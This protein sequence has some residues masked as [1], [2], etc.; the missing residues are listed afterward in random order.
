MTQITLKGKPIHTTGTLPAVGTQA[1]DFTLTKTD[2][3]EINFKKDLAGKTVVLNIFP[4]VDTPTCATAVRKFN[5]TAESLK[6]DIMVLCISADL[7]FA[8]SRFCGAEDLHRVIPASVFRHKEFGE[9]YGVRITDGP[10]AG[11]LSRA[12]VIIDPNGKVIYTEQV[13]EIA[14]EPNYEAALKALS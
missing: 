3:S 5:Q 13:G 10:I 14:H 2:L 12:I 9:Q 4:S 8:L 7:P 1:H 6:E 11:L